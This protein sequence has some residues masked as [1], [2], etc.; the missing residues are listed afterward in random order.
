MRECT[1]YKLDGIGGHQLAVGLTQNCIAIAVPRT[2]S[3]RLRLEYTKGF[4][5]V[6]CIEI[7]SYALFMA[8]G[9]PKDQNKN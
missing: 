1:H 9:F 6:Q 3:S 5:V 7:D 2:W 8:A 4:K